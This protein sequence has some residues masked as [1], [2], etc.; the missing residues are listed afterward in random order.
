MTNVTA[1]IVRTSVAE[2]P[3]AGGVSRHRSERVAC[4]LRYRLEGVD[5]IEVAGVDSAVGHGYFLA[6]P[7][8]HF[9][10]ARGDARVPKTAM[11]SME[12]RSRP[13]PE[14]L[15]PVDPP[16]AGGVPKLSG[17]SEARGN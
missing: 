16:L 4:E 3:A 8:G 9:L 1:S 17:P 14:V 2:S 12:D 7:L 10:G 5:R 15:S 13:T 6:N 11:R